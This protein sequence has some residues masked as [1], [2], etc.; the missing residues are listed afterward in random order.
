MRG[1]V[2]AVLV[3]VVLAL[4]ATVAL[5]A[6]A[7]GADRRAVANQQPVLV[8]VARARIAAG[9]SGEDA[10]NRGLIERTTLPRKAV[11]GGAVRSLEQLGGR[12]AAVDIVPGEQL[13]AARWVGGGEAPGGGLLSIPEG[14]QAVSIALDPTRQVSGFVTPG[15]RVSVVVSLSFPKGGG[16]QRTSRF[17]LLDVQVL[18]VGATA[19]PNPPPRRAAAPVRDAPRARP[20]SPWPSGRRTSN[21]WCSRPRTARCTCRCCHPASGRSRQGAARSTTS[22]RSCCRWR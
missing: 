21:G 22:S 19:Q 7:G 12:V 17:L 3:A 6:Y 18:A 2:V 1:R 9:T 11:A 13:L 4:V 16:S 20:P 8:Y 15:D 14:H 10:Q 5:L